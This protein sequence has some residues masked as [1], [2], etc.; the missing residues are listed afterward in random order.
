MKDYKVQKGCANCA[1]CLQIGFDWPYY[2]CNI[3]KDLPEYNEVPTEDHC[4]GNLFSNEE[5]RTYTDEEY[6]K[7]FMSRSDAW[8]A[9][10]N[11][12]E[13]KPHGICSLWETSIQDLEDIVPIT[14]LPELLMRKGLIGEK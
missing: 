5:A 1:H 10:Q 7:I 4:T 6:E 14:Q 11:K 2:Y 13:I 9:W 12:R 3:N 8:H